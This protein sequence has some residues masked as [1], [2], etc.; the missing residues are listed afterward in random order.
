MNRQQ[1]RAAE[2]LGPTIAPV[3]TG[4]V[5]LVGGPMDGWVVEPDAP[6]LRPDWHETWPRRKPGVLDRARGKQGALILTSTRGYAPGRYVVSERE[7]RWES[8]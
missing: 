4:A 5:R 6:C 7:A 8:Y 1:R 3:D 2:R